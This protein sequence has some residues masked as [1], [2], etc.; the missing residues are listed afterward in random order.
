MVDGLLTCVDWGGT[1]SSPYRFRKYLCELSLGFWPCRL[2][3][4]GIAGPSPVTHR[5]PPA[6]NSASLRDVPRISQCLPLGDL[7]LLSINMR[8]FGQD[9]ND[10]LTHQATRTA[11]L[12]DRVFFPALNSVAARILAA[13]LSRAAQQPTER[14]G[15]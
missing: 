2:K 12:T 7:S 8:G 15:N 13:R 9:A 10:F 11:G 3:F 4:G 5:F 1:A 6:A 14:A